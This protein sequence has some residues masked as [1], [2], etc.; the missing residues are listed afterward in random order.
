MQ[1][2]HAGR[3]IHSSLLGGKLPVSSSPVKMESP[4]RGK[5]LEAI[6]RRES[7]VPR[8]LCPNEIAKIVEHFVTAAENAVLRAG[9]DGVEVHGVSTY[10]YIYVPFGQNSLMGFPVHV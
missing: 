10:A 3:A 7:D 6:G 4:V 9:F 2:W 8:E 5:Y 1:L